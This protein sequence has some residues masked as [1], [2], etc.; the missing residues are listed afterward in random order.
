M[1][2]NAVGDGGIGPPLLVTSARFTDGPRD[3]PHVTEANKSAG[4]SNSHL[5]WCLRQVLGLLRLPL[6]HVGRRVACA[7][8][9][10]ALCLIEGQVP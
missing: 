8:V 3:H 6:R 10:P 4:D 7:G 9:E 1:D 2:K 5:R